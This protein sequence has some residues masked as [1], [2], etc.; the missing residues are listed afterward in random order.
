MRRTILASGN[1]LATGLL[2][3]GCASFSA[4]GGL[5]KVNALSSSATGVTAVALR[6]EEAETSAR[7]RVASLLRT[8]LTAERAAEIALLNN[9]ELQAAYNQLGLSEAEAVE[10]SLPP[11]PK[12]SISRL[13]GGGNYELEGRVVGNILALATLPATADI[14]QDRFAQAQFEAAN[15]TLRIAADAKRA[16]YRAVGAQSLADFLGKAQDSAQAAAQMSS[17][18]AEGGNVNKLDQARNQVFYAEISAQLATARLHA[19]SEREA[20]I[21]ALGLWG[22]DLAFKLPASLPL[23]PRQPGQLPQVEREAIARRLDLQ[24]ARLE[25][26]A[27]AKSY[28]LTDATRFLNLLEVA[29]VGKKMRDA[30]EKSRERGFEAE[31]EIPLFDFGQV[32]SRK[33]EERYMQAVNRLAAKAV[34]VRSEAREAYRGYRARY[35]I[36]QHYQREVMPLRKIISDE[37]LLRYNAMQID[38]FSLLEEARQ[39]ISSTMSAIEA[40]RDFYLAQINL[41]TAILGGGAGATPSAEMTSAMAG[42]GESAGH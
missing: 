18:L 39:R 5:A 16:Y 9:R 42:G 6:S 13:A 30:G 8:P 26:T 35:D 21:R 40:Q 27:L 19:T 37:T 14:A 22:G 25:V 4:D 2:L 10:A 36:A 12:F 15:T 33:A 28:G 38:V 34:N 17:R 31:F 23:P 20:L 32:A 7:A 29:G 3:A 41:G 11:N 24:I 1:L